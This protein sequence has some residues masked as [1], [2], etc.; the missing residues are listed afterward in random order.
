MKKIT[1]IILTAMLFSSMFSPVIGDL[2]HHQDYE[3]LSNLGEHAFER[4]MYHNKFKTAS[5]YRLDTY[6]VP[7]NYRSNKGYVPINRTIIPDPQNNRYKIDTGVYKT[8]FNQ[9]SDIP[10]ELNYDGFF[11]N[12]RP[13]RFSNSDLELMPNQNV[14]GSPINHV[15]PTDTII[16]NINDTFEYPNIFGEDYDLHY[17][18]LPNMLK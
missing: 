3:V 15:F 1:L 6:V 2:T 5:G 12:F 18:Y 16:Y 7:I 11:I 8:Y 10:I 4:G 17:I 14:L 9:N 13:I